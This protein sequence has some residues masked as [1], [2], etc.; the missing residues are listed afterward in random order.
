MK[1]IRFVFECIINA[2]GYAVGD[3]YSST[4]IHNKAVNGIIGGWIF[5]IVSFILI[6]VFCLDYEGYPIKNGRIPFAILI[7]FVIMLLYLALVYWIKY[8]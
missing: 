1:F 4:E 5:V 8:K 3:V 2:L 7:S 6:K